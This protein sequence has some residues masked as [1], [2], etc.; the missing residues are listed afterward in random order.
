MTQLP[1]SPLLNKTNEIIIKNGI[2]KE[3]KFK[4]I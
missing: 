3:L 2:K 4:L 1:L